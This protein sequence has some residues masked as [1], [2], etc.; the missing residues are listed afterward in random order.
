MKIIFITLAVILAVVI[1]GCRTEN[2]QVSNADGPVASAPVKNG[3]TPILLELFTSEGCSSC[4]PA[5]R[6]LGLIA[7]EQ[8]HEQ[9]EIITLGFHVDYWNHD[10]WRDRFSSS[11]FTDRQSAYSRQFKLDGD[12]SPQLVVDGATQVV[13]SNSV[14]VNDAINSRLSS[15]KAIIKTEI[16]SDKLHVDISGIPDQKGATVYLAVAESGLVSNITAG[17]NSGAR[18]THIS[19][20]RD[21]HSIGK[22]AGGGKAI[23]IDTA[24]PTDTAWKVENIKYVVFIQDNANLH[25]LGAS[26]TG[27]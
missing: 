20:V 11:S 2:A 23:T 27:K 19:V 1:L 7:K 24:L 26:Q 21:L 22:I 6:L 18:L 13:G 4:P 5:D 12:Y 14:K 8:P 15:V 3:K 9:T 16:K 17:E 10:G 25:I